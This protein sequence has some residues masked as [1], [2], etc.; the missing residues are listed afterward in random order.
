MKQFKRLNGKG[1]MSQLITAIALFG[2]VQSSHAH[3]AGATMDPTGNSATFTG[4]ALVTCA[5]DDN[6][7]P[8]K[9]VASIRD[10]SPPVP[11]LLVNLQIITVPGGGLS[12][13]AVSVTDPISGDEKSS[14]VV[15]INGK[16]KPYY[17]LVN[18]TAPGARD[19][20]VQYHCMTA[21]DVHTGTGIVVYQFE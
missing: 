7:P 11:G 21:N 16:D 19:F 10:H 4:Y 3:D 18:K 13:R 6:G 5:D 2:L 15:S 14:P 17:I 8:E 9:L 1:L 20:S 12:P